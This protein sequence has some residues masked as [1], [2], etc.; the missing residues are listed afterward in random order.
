MRHGVAVVAGLL[1]ASCGSAAETP[2]ED[3]R[4]IAYEKVPAWTGV[5]VDWQTAPQ[6]HLYDTKVFQGHAAFVNLGLGRGLSFSEFMRW[7]RYPAERQFMPFF[8]Y[9]LREDAIIRDGVRMTW[10]MRLEDY[11]Y[12]DAP[13][14]MAS[15]LARL[16]ELI[17]PLV[18]GFTPKGLLIVSASEQLGLGDALFVDGLAKRGYP[19]ATLGVLLRHVGAP[20]LQVLNPG[21]AVGELVHVTAPEQVYDLTYRHIAVFAFVPERVPPVSGIITLQPQTPLSHVNLLARN[22]GTFNM[23]LRDLD[24]LPK[25]AA[26]LGQLI[27]VDS[28]K[29]AVGVKP[30]SEEDAEVFWEAHRPPPLTIPKPRMLEGPLISL[31][32]PSGEGPTTSQVGAKAANYGALRALLGEALV[33]PGYALGF[34]GYFQV[35]EQE[36]APLIAQLLDNKDT[37]PPDEKRRR[38]EEIQHALMRAEAPSPTLRALRELILDQYPRTRIRLRSSTNCEDLPRFNGAGLYESKGFNTHE[39]DSVLARKLLQVYASLWNFEAF[40]ERDYAGI[41]HRRAG[42]AV[43]INEAFS[44]ELANGVILTVPQPEGGVEILVNAQPGDAPVVRPEKPVVPESFRFSREACT[45]ADVFSRSSLGD[46]FVENEAYEPLLV[47]MKGATLKVHAYFTERQARKGDK[48]PYGVDIEF[49]V[50]AGGAGPSLCFK[51]ARL[52]G[53]QLPEQAGE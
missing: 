38:L 49:K 44:D 42:M 3:Y 30:I 48:A 46:V 23:Y 24:V 5:A 8:L 17:P 45:V 20:V 40:M 53:A 27:Q 1:V 2:V 50:M 41:D 7:T 37:M 28:E 15:E 9:D 22:R 47:R 39:D 29:G 12:R 34:D 4:F 19:C 13:G 6:V 31:E 18:E 26:A 32:A 35:A 25:L 36:A 11:E 51:Q 43:L 10:A 14:G 21:T 16:A 52:L 33:R